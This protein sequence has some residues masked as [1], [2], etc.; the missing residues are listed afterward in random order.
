MEIAIRELASKGAHSYSTLC[1]SMDCSP[2]GSSVHEIF[3]ARILKWVAIFYS[4][5]LPYPVIEPVFLVSPAL[6]G[7]FFTTVPSE[8]PIKEFIRVIKYSKS[9]LDLYEVK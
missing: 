2:S 1:N 5:G 4:R 3:Q 6:A 8:K 9:W 7:R